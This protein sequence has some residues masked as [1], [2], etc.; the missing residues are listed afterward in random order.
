MTKSREKFMLFFMGVLCFFITQILLRLPLLSILQKN[1]QWNQWTFAYPFIFTLIVA[2][3]AGFFE[4]GGRFLFRKFLLRA[5]GENQGYFPFSDRW[6]CPL[7][8]GLGHGICELVFLLQ[9]SHAITPI[10]HLDFLGERIIALVFHIGMSF[11]IFQG[12]S[13]N[14][15]GRAFLLAFFLHGFFDSLIFFLSW[16]YLAVYGLWIIGDLLIINRI[17]T[18]RKEAYDEKH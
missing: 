12:C 3:S 17:L 16:S 13:H 8:F 5:P 1:L 7:I 6:E 2:F 9:L 15:G 14:Q 4:E 10:F 11:L 18:V